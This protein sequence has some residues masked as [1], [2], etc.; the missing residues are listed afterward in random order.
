[1]ESLSFSIYLLF[2]PFRKRCSCAERDSQLIWET[3][4]VGDKDS[5]DFGSRSLHERLDSSVK[6]G[7]EECTYNQVP[8]GAK[9]LVLNT[10]DQLEGG[11][12]LTMATYRFIRS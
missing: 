7:Q 12:V 8:D 3:V 2:V 10:G 11:S 9:R 5:N 4:R 1:M 6:V